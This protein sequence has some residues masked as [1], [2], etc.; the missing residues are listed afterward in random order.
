MVTRLAITLVFLSTA[1]ATA[2]DGLRGDQIQQRVIG[3]TLVGTDDDSQYF[4]YFGANGTI[5]GQGEDGE[6]SGHWFIRGDQLCVAYED[7]DGD[8][9]QTHKCSRVIV[10][11][12]Q[13]IGSSIDE[14]DP[15]TFLLG[16]PH[17]RAAFSTISPDP[18]PIH[19][20]QTDDDDA[21]D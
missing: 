19:D 13:I 8:I 1:G 21:R 3:N 17:A 12:D 15:L 7:D 18:D 11:R 9:P 10:S 16:N 20:A 5:V 6:Y 14:D 4:E 2:A